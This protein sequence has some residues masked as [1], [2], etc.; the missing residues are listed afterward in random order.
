MKNF[1][2]VLAVMT[3]VASLCMSATAFAAEGSVSSSQNL[4]GTYDVATNVLNI[5]NNNDVLADSETTILVLTSELTDD[6]AANVTEGKIMYINQ[7]N[8]T[9]DGKNFTGMG[10][11]LPTGSETLAVGTYPVKVGCYNATTRGF[12]IKNATLEVT[13][14]ASGEKTI[15]VRLGDF[16]GDKLFTGTDALYALKAAINVYD[17]CTLK[18][19]TDDT[20]QL[21]TKIGADIEIVTGDSAI[22]TKLGDFN[23]DKLFTGTDALYALKA[24]I[25]VFD[26]CTLKD[27]TDETKQLATKIGADITVK[28]PE[29]VT[30]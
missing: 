10:L 24:A 9:T 23:G 27:T 3:A 30:E 13:D 19:T 18:D 2:K 29:T 16:N 22:T 5:T 14:D 1:K 11:K 4:A 12:E 25:N 26:N 28:V 21:A 17:N 6:E 15:T 20:K 8:T 7:Q